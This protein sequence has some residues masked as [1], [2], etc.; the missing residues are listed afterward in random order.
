LSKHDPLPGLGAANVGQEILGAV[1]VHM[2]QI[3]GMAIGNDGLLVGLRGV[4]K[5]GQV[6]VFTFPTAIGEVCA[7]QL[8]KATEGAQRVLAVADAPL[9]QTLAV[10]H[11]ET[12]QVFDKGELVLIAFDPGGPGQSIKGFPPGGA[13]AL[14][15]AIAES[16]TKAFSRQ[17][18][19][20]I[21]PPNLALPN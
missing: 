9:Q 18:K 16:A 8:K 6:V 20:L 15:R 11:P 10:E 3:V 14:A 2:E 1:E 12:F 7:S 4:D 21:L 5:T 19:R 13:M 17:P